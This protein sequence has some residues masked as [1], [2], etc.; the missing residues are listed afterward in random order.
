MLIPAEGDRRACL[1]W[2]KEPG[3]RWA[4]PVIIPCALAIGRSPH[5]LRLLRFDHY[6]TSS[7]SLSLPPQ[8]I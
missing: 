2:L 1:E 5:L 3:I 4:T 6:T 7:L 8:K